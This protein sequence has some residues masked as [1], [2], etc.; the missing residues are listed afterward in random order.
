[1]PFIFIDWLKLFGWCGQSHTGH[2]YFP[3]FFLVL[4]LDRVGRVTGPVVSFNPIGVWPAWASCKQYVYSRNLNFWY[5]KIEQNITF[6][7]VLT[8]TSTI[9]NIGSLYFLLGI[10]NLEA[11]LNIPVSELTKVYW[12]TES[13]I[14]FKLQAVWP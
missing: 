9:N 3:E 10:Y 8:K 5:N 1:M 11:V 14:N 13:T 4:N 6:A 2:L 7:N 12:P